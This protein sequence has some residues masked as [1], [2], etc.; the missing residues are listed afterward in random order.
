[1]YLAGIGARAESDP[2]AVAIL[3]RTGPLTWGELA[4][5]VQGL[6][7]ALSTLPPSARVGVT[8]DNVAPTLVTHLAGLLAGV[9]TVALHRQGTARELAQELSDTGCALAVT[10]SAADAAVR[11]AAG[12]AGVGRVIAHPGP[13]WAELVATPVV[14]ID[15]HRKPPR[16]LLV[17][18]SG[19]TGRAAATEVTWL[20]GPAAPDARAY[21]EAVATEPGF[22]PGPHLVAGPLQHNGPLTALRHLLAGEPVVVVERFDAEEVLR[23]IQAHAVTSTV[24]VPTHF[25]RLLALAPEV[26]QAYDVGSLTLVAHTG[27]ACPEDV[28]RAMIAWWGPV[29]VESY[30]GSELG[31]VCRIGSADWLRRPGSVGRAVP[32]LVVEAYDEDG[33]VQP[34][35]TTGI[36]GVTLPPGRAVRFHG[37]EAKS[38]RA[39]LAPDVATLGDVGHVDAD[40]FVFITDRVSDLV[41]S[42]GVNLYPAE[43][44]QVLLRH[45][46]VREVAVIGVPDPDLGETLLALVVPTDAVDSVDTAALDAFCRTELAGYKCPRSYE[47][48]PTLPRNDMGKLDKRALRDS[49]RPALS[50]Q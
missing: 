43:C 49:Y 31:T 3:G 20:R 17:F 6:A 40:G 12:A 5:Q 13:D 21:V 28:K 11:E 7:A 10:G 15:L 44:E 48:V 18:T 23:L 26:R 8:G 25:T 38:A 2:H 50:E 24:M 33:R 16:P 4:T 45:P 35:G 32:P 1:M 14:E 34:R 47:I 27:S 42:G 39:Y 29:F 19:T 37:D 41:I 22:P 9:G 46:A 30:G 36:L